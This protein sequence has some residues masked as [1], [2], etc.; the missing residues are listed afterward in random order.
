[1]FPGNI[2]PQDLGT[3]N[4]EEAADVWCKVFSIFESSSWSN[5]ALASA[6]Q[7]MRVSKVVGKIVRIAREE[8]SVGRNTAEQ[9]KAARI[10]LVFMFVRTDAKLSLSRPSPMV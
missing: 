8:L 7:W 9:E 1:M 2:K 5:G 3:G 4:D 10:W 6:F